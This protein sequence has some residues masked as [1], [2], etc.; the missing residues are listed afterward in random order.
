M[1]NYLLEAVHAQ[2]SYLR[3]QDALARTAQRLQG[4]DEI[5]DDERAAVL[6]AVETAHDER[7]TE[8]GSRPR[9]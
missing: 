1:Q 3:R 4:S 5:P 2:A 6:E 7:A 8:L 9:Q